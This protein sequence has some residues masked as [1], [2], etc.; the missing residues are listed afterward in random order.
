VGIEPPQDAHRPIAP[1]LGLSKGVSLAGIDD[2][3][4]LDPLRLEAAPEFEGLGS[5]T[6][7]VVL[8][9]EEQGRRLRLPAPAMAVWKR[10]VW[11]TIHIAMKPP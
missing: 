7:S 2:E 1:V 5:G 10:V 8:S 4:R 3:L 6:L 9:D 11:V